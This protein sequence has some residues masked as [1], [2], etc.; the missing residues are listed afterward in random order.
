MYVRP[1]EIGERM[2]VKTLISRN[3]RLIDLEILIY[4]DA[5]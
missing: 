1:H 3:I 4:L 5:K 2:P